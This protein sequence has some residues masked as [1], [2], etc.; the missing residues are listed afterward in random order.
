[1]TSVA[2]DM[3]EPATE[4]RWRSATEVIRAAE[5]LYEPGQDLSSDVRHRLVRDLAKQAARQFIASRKHDQ[6]F[7]LLAVLQVPPELV[8]AEWFH[9]RN[10]LLIYE[11]KRVARVRRV[12]QML[13]ICV[14]TYLLLIAP[15]IFVSLENPYRTSHAMSELDWSEGLYWSVMT[16]TTVGYGDI[17]PQTPYARLLS[18]FD[19]VLGVT[20]M[21]VIAGLILSLVT[22]RR[23][24]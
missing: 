1:M 14:L 10:S 16:S 4:R 13:L 7:R 15:T 20:L 11:Q 6:A 17:V 23:F 21:G 8:D 22:A 18:L 5:R 9:L 24:D 2:F 3:N 12:L 19:A